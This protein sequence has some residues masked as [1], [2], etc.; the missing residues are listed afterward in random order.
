MKTFIITL[1]TGLI[2]FLGFM[3]IFVKAIYNE[4][5]STPIEITHGAINIQ[6][7]CFGDFIGYN[8]NGVSLIE[9]R[10][11]KDA[12]RDKPSACFDGEHNY[13]IGKV[14]LKG[15]FYLNKYEDG[16]IY[17][18]YKRSGHFLWVHIE[19]YYMGCE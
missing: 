7:D 12:C 3:G 15:D 14:G 17:T 11:C 8:I 9:D 1:S 5:Q 2:I 6:K 4:E 13:Y 18:L 16:K 19:R 10:I